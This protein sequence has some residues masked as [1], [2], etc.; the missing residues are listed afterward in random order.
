MLDEDAGDIEH[1]LLSL[2]SVDYGALKQAAALAQTD[3]NSYVI[4][5]ALDAAISLIA[6]PRQSHL[7]ERDSIRVMELLENPPEPNERM[8]AAARALP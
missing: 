4:Q 7:S 2:H 5:A 3:L 6:T 8:I 1:L